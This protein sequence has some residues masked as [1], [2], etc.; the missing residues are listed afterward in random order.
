LILARV[1]PSWLG[2]HVTDRFGPHGAVGGAF[3]FAPTPRLSIW[4]EVDA[5]LQTRTAGGHTWVVVNETSLEVYRGIWLKFSPQLRTSDGAPGSSSRRR[6]AFAADF[7]PRTHWNVNV[8][9][10][11]DHAFDAST[12]TLV[13]QLHLFM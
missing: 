8:A 1:R 12:S 9:Y 11:L 6:L 3:G 5:N 10:Y 7:L 4:T 2:L 13:A